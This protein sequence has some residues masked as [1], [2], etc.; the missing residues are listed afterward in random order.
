MKSHHRRRNEVALSFDH[1]DELWVAAL[2]L[3]EEERSGFIQAHLN[4]VDTSIWEELEQVYHKWQ[5]SYHSE[6]EHDDDIS[7][8]W[9]S[10]NTE[11]ME[12]LS[13]KAQD[14]GFD[15]SKEELEEFYNARWER[16]ARRG[17]VPS[18]VNLVDHPRRGVTFELRSAP[19]YHFSVGLFPE[20]AHYLP[21]TY[22]QTFWT[23]VVNVVEWQDTESFSDDNFGYGRYTEPVGYLRLV[24]DFA[25]RLHDFRRE[26]FEKKAEE[27]P[28]RAIEQ[29]ITDVAGVDKALAQQL[30]TLGLSQEETL[31]LASEMYDRAHD[32]TRNFV[33]RELHDYLD[34]LDPTK[35][36][37]DPPPIVLSVSQAL[38]REWGIT[39]GSMYEEAPWTLYSLRPHELRQEGFVMRHCVGKQGM[40]YVRSVAAGEVAIWSLRDRRGKPRFTLEADLA[41]V[42]EG[43][44]GSPWGALDIPGFENAPYIEQ[45]N[46]IEQLK[47]K[48]NRLP[49]FAGVGGAFSF[50]EEVIF[51]ARVL[52]LLGVEAEPG[53]SED[54][55]TKISDLRPGL[56]ALAQERRANRRRRPR[57]W[58]Y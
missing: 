28:T 30:Q 27:D 25:E 58:Y 26:A 20:W 22:A 8:M 45:P 5:H 10:D 51:W 48:A 57:R 56:Q 1:I 39:R 38:M 18:I 9:S 31:D 16:S 32:E 21:A 53:A 44:L 50:P 7:Y 42:G 12:W 4:E 37:N 3:P 40:G 52:T 19:S 46:A 35:Q 11:L 54:P 17:D 47:G 34:L 13:Q 55:L 6:A 2:S 29:F 36:S 43:G 14:T 23:K 33:R 49:G 24:D 41:Q 15:L